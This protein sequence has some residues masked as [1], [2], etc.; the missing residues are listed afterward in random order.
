[1]D[2]TTIFNGRTEIFI[3][4]SAFK[5]VLL[6]N[7]IKCKVSVRYAIAIVMDSC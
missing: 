3:R 7:S 4:Q 6:E 5:A 2:D 1:M